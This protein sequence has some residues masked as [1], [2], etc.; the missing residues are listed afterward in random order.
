[1]YA[2]STLVHDRGNDS[3]INASLLQHRAG[4]LTLTVTRPTSKQGTAL[5]ISNLS[6]PVLLT[7]P[8]APAFNDSNDSLACVWWDNSTQSYSAEGCQVYHHLSTANT[9]VCAC[10][11]LTEF[12]VGIFEQL[13]ALETIDWSKVD[14]RDVVPFAGMQALSLVDLQALSWDELVNADPATVY[15]VMC[16]LVLY[17]MF[18]PLAC[19]S[20]RRRIK[21]FKVTHILTRLARKFI[22]Y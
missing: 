10:T 13:G 17:V 5:H 7:L 11:H 21:R 6:S 19:W 16:L 15:Y 8:H 9:T 22:T 20:D 18:L 2:D 1:L 3:N 4:V 14:V 12:S